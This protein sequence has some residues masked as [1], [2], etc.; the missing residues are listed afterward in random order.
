VDVPLNLPTQIQA[1][2]ANGNPIQ[3]VTVLVG[4]SPRQGDLV[5]ARPVEISGLAPGLVQTADPA[6]VDVLLSG[7]S[8]VL[9]RIK[10]DP[11]LVRV[12][13]NAAN[14]VPDQSASL[15]PDV[16]AP[17]G[18]QAQLIPPSVVVTVSSK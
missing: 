1:L 9:D 18:V 14:V 13:A 8:P 5:I 15:K 10:A 6:T 7:P 2:D 11:S 4:I 12:L 17:T 16:I 3:T